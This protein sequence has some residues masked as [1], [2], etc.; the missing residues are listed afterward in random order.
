MFLSAKIGVILDA[1]FFVNGEAYLSIIHSMADLPFT[2]YSYAVAGIFSIVMWLLRI[3]V[4]RSSFLGKRFFHCKIRIVVFCS[5]QRLKG[6]DNNL[7]SLASCGQIDR[8]SVMRFIFP[9]FIGLCFYYLLVSLV[10]PLYVAFKACYA[11]FLDSVD[12]GFHKVVIYTAFSGYG[13]V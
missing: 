2:I 13:E 1:R 9:S 8:R 3:M 5:G 7:L 4:L 10:L 6:I 11:L 12:V